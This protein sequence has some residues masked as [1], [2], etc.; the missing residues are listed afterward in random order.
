[1]QKQWEMI[2]GEE[3][4]EIIEVQKEHTSRELGRRNEGQSRNESDW[5]KRNKGNLARRETGTV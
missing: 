3:S 5:K 2:A 1:M 4:K